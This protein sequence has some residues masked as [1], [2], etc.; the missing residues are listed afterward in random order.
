MDNETITAH[1]IM[2]DIRKKAV[3]LTSDVIHDR[4]LLK[5]RKATVSENGSS[6]KK[7]KLND[8]SK[9]KP[10]L[11]AYRIPRNTNNTCPSWLYSHITAWLDLHN[12][13]NDDRSESDK[14]KLSNFQWTW[15]QK[16][17][18]VKFRKLEQE[19]GST[20]HH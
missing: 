6:W 2:D 1:T 9:D 17:N 14:A 8:H 20:S 13:P 4:L 7:V 3:A 10:A 12:I 5:S 11:S 18:P 19:N 15:P 16:N